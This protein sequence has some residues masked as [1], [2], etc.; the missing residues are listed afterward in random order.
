MDDTDSILL[1]SVRGLAFVGVS[2]RN[3][4]AYAACVYF[5]V[6]EGTCIGMWGLC[7]PYVHSALNLS[8]SEVGAAAFCTFLGVFSGAP[9]TGLLM[10]QFGVQR[11]IYAAGIMYG[12]MLPFLVTA[13]GF[14]TLVPIM[15]L[16]GLLWGIV[17]TSANNAVVLSEMVDGKS[18]M[19]S[20]YGAYSIAA[21]LCSLIGGLMVS[22][23]TSIHTIL[24]FSAVLGSLCTTVFATVLYTMKQEQYI[25]QCHVLRTRICDGAAAAA[26]K[27]DSEE[28]TI[29]L[30][31]SL[32]NKWC[33]HWRA[34]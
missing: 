32:A 29:E 26:S 23:D 18:R 17:D 14:G 10:V 25:Q 24:I 5:F 30:S 15:Y 4:F 20:C 13:S 8:D 21:G 6:L 7:V 12:I 27:Q 19:G 31:S 16:F 22:G 9:L 28:V 1:E 2:Q 33:M 3:S 34:T 11:T